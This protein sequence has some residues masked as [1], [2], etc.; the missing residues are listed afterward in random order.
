M[1]I[2]LAVS[3][4]REGTSKQITVAA[5]SFKVT[6]DGIC[7]VGQSE[8][9]GTA[10]IQCKTALNEPAFAAHLDPVSTTCTLPD[11]TWPS[12]QLRRNDGNSSADFGGGAGLFPV[13]PFEINFGAAGDPSGQKA[14][15]SIVCPGTKFTVA[16][17]VPF[18]RYSIETEIQA[19][20]LGSYRAFDY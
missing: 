1:R 2:G 11:T 4:Y 18:S 9:W 6:D 17:P 5:G 10:T 15:V 8:Y 13:R 16:T 3:E 12:L 14:A 20:H 19:V 7:A